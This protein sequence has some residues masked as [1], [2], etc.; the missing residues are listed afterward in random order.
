MSV[1]AD[2]GLHLRAWLIRPVVRNGDA[3]IILHGQADNRSG[4]LGIA[5]VMLR[6]CY[7]VLLP[8]SRGQGLSEGNLVTYGVRE[9]GDL[10]HWF[11]WISQSEQPHCIYGVG[12]SMG[13]AQLLQ[14][15][16]VE[17]AFCAVVAECS[18]ATFREAS[19]DRIGQQMGAG[20]WV[21]R[22]LFRPVVEFGLLYA[23]WK[24]GVDLAQA[25]P[26]KVVAGSRTPVLLIHGLKDNNLPPRHSEA[27]FAK[28][29]GHNP[30]VVLWEPP[31]AGHC[32]AFGAEPEEYE[33]HLIGWLGMNDRR[34]PL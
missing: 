21:G 2:D 13:A 30:N 25:S 26:E 8:D 19:F 32:G 18:F 14:S 29:H 10:R 34:A 12:E 7:T 9:A 15:L 33:R 24:Y 27:I 31:Q 6:H 4:V 17:P 5:D 20:S 1:I 23:R 28:S 3:V 22:V 16:M 11:D